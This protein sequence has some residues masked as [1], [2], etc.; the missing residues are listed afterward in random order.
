METVRDFIEKISSNEF[1]GNDVKVLIGIDRN[2]FLNNYLEKVKVLLESRFKGI[3][4][5]EEIESIVNF[6]ANNLNRNVK[7]VIDVT[8]TDEEQEIYLKFNN[9]DTNQRKEIEQSEIYKRFKDK[10]DIGAGPGGYTQGRIIYSN[11]FKTEEEFEI[12]K[13]H[14]TTHAARCVIIDKETKK[15]V[16]QNNDIFD[17]QEL[18]IH[19]NPDYIANSYENV[20]A[21]AGYDKMEVVERG[22]VVE[23]PDDKQLTDLMETCTEAIAEMMSYNDDRKVKKFLNFWIPT[24][25]MKMSAIDYDRHMR[26]C[27]IM[28]IGSDEFI[29][30][31]LEEDSDKGFIKLNQIIQQYKENGS[32]LEY[33]N[34]A[35]EYSKCLTRIESGNEDEKYNKETLNSF[36]EK[37][38]SYTTD[39]FLSRMQNGSDI[40]KNEQIKYYLSILQTEQAKNRIIQRSTGKNG[41]ED[42]LDDEN[43]RISTEQKATKVV[44]ETVIGKEKT[45]E[46][47][48]QTK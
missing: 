11:L 17:E 34:I 19:G 21:T 37:L 27:L 35:R 1:Y 4:T 12:L 31:M 7:Y 33:L 46:E 2:A 47:T 22:N 45:I 26:D 18:R 6:L 25:E 29:F 28:A 44:K 36:F 3:K 30:D 9:A 43:L 23:N 15:P 42:C 8:Y 39:I 32:I 41:L 48:E 24:N 14:E 20:F 13:S 5:E 16:I 40:D 10:H 38:E